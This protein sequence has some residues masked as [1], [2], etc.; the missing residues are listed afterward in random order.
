MAGGHIN[1]DAIDNSA[2]VDTSDHEVNLKILLQPALSSGRIGFDRRNHALAAAA[3]EVA[4]LVLRDNRDRSCCSAS[5]Q[6][7]RPHP[8]QRISRITRARSSSAAGWRGY[9][10]ALTQ[11][12][13]AAR[14]PPPLRRPYP[15]ELAVLSA[16]TKIDMS[17]QLQACTLLNDPYLSERFLVPYF[18]ASIVREFAEEIRGTGCGARSL[19]RGWS[20][21]WST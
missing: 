5:E 11:P 12:R 21:N 18:P 1:T 13:G 10:A 20:M 2:G 19:S 3:G 14:S 6:L 17:A 9:A 15:P 8:R 4:A 7:R 16:Y